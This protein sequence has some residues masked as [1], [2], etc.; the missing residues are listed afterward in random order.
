MDLQDIKKEIES[1]RKDT[2]NVNKNTEIYLFG[3]SKIKLALI[4]GI[5]AL[6]IYIIKPVYIYEFEL[7]SEKEIKRRL[8]Y[9]STFIAYIVTVIML[10]IGNKFINFNFI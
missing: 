5:A 4:F 2:I 6:L 9:K 10:F 8:N 1:L 3:L 7:D